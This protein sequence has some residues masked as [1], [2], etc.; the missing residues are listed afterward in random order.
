[1]KSSNYAEGYFKQTG[2]EINLSGPI[3]PTS[4]CIPGVHAGHHTEHIPSIS[5]DQKIT[6]D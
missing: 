6:C 5:L 3:Q 4:P 2:G 1:M